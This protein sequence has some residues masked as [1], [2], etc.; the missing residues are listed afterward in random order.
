MILAVIARDIIEGN[1]EGV[2]A[3]I[4][5]RAEEINIVQGFIIRVNS[6]IYFSSSRSRGRRWI[7]KK[8][9]KFFYL[10]QLLFK[11]IF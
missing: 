8:I 1:Q 11:S 4:G 3:G 6:F 10:I 9:K 7:K 5:I 2:K